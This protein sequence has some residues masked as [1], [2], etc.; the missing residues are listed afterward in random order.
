MC[1]V[2]IGLFN[3][4]IYSYSLQFQR[5]SKDCLQELAFISLDRFAF[6]KHENMN[7]QEIDYLKKQKFN[8]KFGSYE[9][10]IKSLKKLVS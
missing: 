3:K 9:D 1:I 10:D 5:Y 8:I 2:E 6:Q 7:N 4:F